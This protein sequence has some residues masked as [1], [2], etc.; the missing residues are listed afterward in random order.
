VC[1]EEGRQ[2][3]LPEHKTSSYKYRFSQ[4]LINYIMVLLS[5]STKTLLLDFELEILSVN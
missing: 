4:I 3:S 2:V 5:C 1:T